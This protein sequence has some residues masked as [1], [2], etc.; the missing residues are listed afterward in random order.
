[1]LLYVHIPFC[2]SKCGYCAFNSF[3]VEQDNFESYIQA[4]CADIEHTLCHLYPHSHISSIFFGGGTPNLLHSEHYEAIF[5][6]LYKNAFISK[7]C[8]ITLEANVNY[9]NTQWCKDLVSLGANR[10]SVGIQSFDKDKIAFL[11]REHSVYEIAKCVENAYN[12]GFKNISCDLIINTPLDSKTLISSEITQAA[13]LPLSHISVY[14]L[15]IDEGSRFFL[16]SKKSKPIQNSKT[17]DSK[18]DEELS[19]WARECLKENGFYQYEVSNYVKFNTNAECK[20]NLGYWQGEEYL[21]CGA[22]AVGRIVNKRTRAYPSLN[23]YIKNPYYRLVEELSEEDLRL[24]QIMLGLRCV[25]GVDM[26]V[27]DDE[28]FLKPLFDDKKCFR[29]SY[30]GKLFL[31]ADELFLADEIATWILCRI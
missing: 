7:D 6:I 1:M 22:G 5:T 24:E 20:H 29:K 16:E 28:R 23:E 15:S 31:V 19:F 13:A 18:T 12:G 21:G 9:L 10:L 17:I 11:E 8:E 27:F 14:T 2:G 26:A 30:N 25:K 4:L 3:V